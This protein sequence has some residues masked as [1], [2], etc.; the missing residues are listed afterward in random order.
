MDGASEDQVWWVRRAVV[1]VL[2]VVGVVTAV[3]AVVATRAEDADDSARDDGPAE[4]VTD[5]LPSSGVSNGPLRLGTVLVAGRHGDPVAKPE[6]TAESYADALDAGVDYVEAQVVM[7]SDE[8]L[9]VRGD[10]ELSRSTDVADRPE[11]ADR[12][13]TKVVDGVETTGW[14]SEDFTL[15]E[16]RTLRATEPDPAL[17]PDS[18][19]YDGDFGLISFDDLLTQV[20]DFNL[21]QGT[22]VGVF[23]EPL[24]ASYFRGLRLAVEPAIAKSLRKARLVNEPERVTVES[25]D[26]RVLA[27]LEANLG[28]NVLS[29]LVV[30][31]DSSRLLTADALAGLP[32]TID[33]IIV[34]SEAFTKV[35]EPQRVPDLVH[36]A[37]FAI[38][39]YPVSFENALLG[40][41]F[42]VGT[43]PAGVG[44]L[45]KLL[46]GVRAIGFDVLLAESPTEVIETLDALEQADTDEPE[47]SDAAS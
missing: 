42:K 33:V 45:E 20:N 41:D 37:G 34:E 4:V 7:T 8:Q 15:D 10:N 3:F 43:D 27:R 40:E 35:D 44:D 46:R 2:V 19:A 25:A 14:F 31:G 38:G 21:A 13:T 16:L 17:R 30:D 1:A 28:D 12:E 47:P 39:V 32:D 23:V 6:H 5:F 22:E 11:F 9:L 26:L 18:A 24:R 29:G 36:A